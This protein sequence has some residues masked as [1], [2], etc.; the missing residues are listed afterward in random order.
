MLPIWKVDGDLYLKPLGLQTSCN[1]A[2][3]VQTDI[4]VKC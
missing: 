4:V 1:L 3:R 2:G